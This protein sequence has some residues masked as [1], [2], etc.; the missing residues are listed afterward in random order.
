MLKGKVHPYIPNS[1]EGIKNEMLKELG[2]KSAEDIFSAIPE[3]LRYRGK[4]NIPEPIISEARLRR[5]IE[6]MLAKNRNCKNNISFLGGGCWHHYVPSVCDTIGARDEFLTAYVGEAYSDHGKFQA[7]FE[8]SSMIGDLTG[9]EACNT[10]IYDWASA[11]AMAGRMACRTKG[12]HQILVGEDISPSRLMV[13]ENYWKP[14][15]EIIKVKYNFEKGGMDLNDLKSK[16]SDKTTAVYFENPSYLGFIETAVKE[17]VDVAHDAGAFVISGVDPSS[18][19]ILEAPGNYGADYAVGDYQPMGQHM[20]FGG[21]QGGWVATKDD[22]DMVAE[23]PSLLFGLTHTTKEGEWGFGEVFFERTSYASREKGKDFV[24]TTTALFGIVAGV[25]MALM[26]PQGFKELGE[27]IMQRVAYAKQKIAALPK[28]KIASENALIFKEFLV[29]F[30]DTGK[31]V[32]EINKA[33]LAANIF[34]GKDISREF[35]IFGQSALYCITEMHT[36]DDIDKFVSV[37]GNICAA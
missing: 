14:E 4:M 8:T 33:L 10:P 13:I 6:K 29:D 5:H 27:G 23:Y 31:T 19:G 36:K 28:I 30:N 7:L 3:H 21:N 20:G 34:G 16:I 22:K 25:Y 35:P 1:E 24:G 9:F 11:I 18:L 32:E 12:R 2:M 26:G 37:L 17:I 15:I